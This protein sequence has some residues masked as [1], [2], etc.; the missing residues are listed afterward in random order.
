MVSKEHNVYRKK[1]KEATHLEED[2]PTSMKQTVLNLLELL[3]QAHDID[4]RLEAYYYS[5]RGGERGRSDALKSDR[6]Y[7]SENAIK[8]RGCY[9]HHV[10]RK[11]LLRL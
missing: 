4:V 5:K 1:W 6:N 2:K 3:V 11:E 7:L 10:G 9:E 8:V